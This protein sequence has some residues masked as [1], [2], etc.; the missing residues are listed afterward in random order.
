MQWKHRCSLEWLLARR[1]YLTASDVHNLVPFTKTGRKRTVLA[2]DYDRLI[3]AKSVV[4]T[5]DDCVSTGAAARGHW[6]EPQAVAFC[7][8]YY[9]TRFYHWDDCIIH[10]G[11]LAYSPDAMTI[12]QP[13]GKVDID[14]TQITEPHDIL[15][16]KCYAP[17]RHLDACHAKD[18]ELEER[19]QIATAMAVDPLI[20]EAKL[21]FFCPKCEAW[22]FNLV[23][24]TR[25][26][27]RK[28]IDIIMEI[29]GN[30]AQH[31]NIASFRRWSDFS[32]YEDAAEQACKEYLSMNPIL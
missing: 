4:L 10:H 2:E 5:E 15:E 1:K 31:V 9:G 23:V 17:T 32:G 24:Y 14:V 18:G 22:P 30:W 20:N 27:L 29:W 19:W 28:E 11:C 16:I 8:D 26:D 7:N 13:K 21:L 12:E 3:M 6:M 25:E